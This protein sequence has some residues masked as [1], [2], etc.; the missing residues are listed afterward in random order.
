MRLV[1]V[2][3]HPIM[4][5][6]LV[7]VMESQPDMEVV[8]QGSSAKDAV[9]LATALEPDL[10]LLDLGIRGGGIE[11]LSEIV[12]CFPN[13]KCVMLT[14]CDNADTA[15]RALNA[16]A[17][18][19]ILKGI[20]ANELVVALWTVFRDES[21]VSPE[22]ATKLL[23]AMQAVATPRQKAETLSHREAQIMREVE[24]GFT[25]R[26]IAEK[27]EISEKT[28]K[29]YM[30]AIMQKLGVSNRVAA[31]IAAQKN[32]SINTA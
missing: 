6:G 15:I 5:D 3:D 10:I 23:I 25:N 31:V 14:A 22:F 30:S 1:I 28:V 27:L 29:H 17:K 20:G 21:F 16:G 8:G 7:S 24:N 2:D 32:R 19:Y 18:G 13:V 12:K 9:S 4:R 11:A 26:Q